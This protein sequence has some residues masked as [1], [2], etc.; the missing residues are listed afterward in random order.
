MGVEK[1]RQPRWKDWKNSPSQNSLRR[2][3]KNE[4]GIKQ[5][6]KRFLKD[7]W[8]NDHLLHQIPRPTHCQREMMM[9][10]KETGVKHQWMFLLMKH[11]S[12]SRG[13]EVVAR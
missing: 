3:R 11:M 10:K 9:K 7:T 13:V 1:D 6:M 2:M 8:Q 4:K 12:V 5:R